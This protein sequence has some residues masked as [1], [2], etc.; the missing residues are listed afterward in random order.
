MCC[1]TFCALQ[2]AAFHDT[3]QLLYGMLD[4]DD[5]T[6]AG[7]LAERNFGRFTPP[8]CVYCNS[9][10]DT[11][12]FVAKSGPEQPDCAADRLVS[13]PQATDHH[14]AALTPSI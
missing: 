12:D 11:E 14:P 5:R 1:E 10:D 13:A 3:N 2:H 9:T 8:L 6:K 7:P 4:E